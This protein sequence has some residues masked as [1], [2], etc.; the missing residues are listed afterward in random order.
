M[1]FRHL[2]IRDAAYDAI[3]KT[4]RAELHERF[5]AW[6]DAAG[7]SLGEQDEIVGYHL[8]QAYRYRLELGAD[9][10]T[11][12]AARRRRRSAP[13]GRR[14]A[15]V[16]AERLLGVDQSPRAGVRRCSLS[17]IHCELSILPDLGSAL[18]EAGDMNGARAHFDEAIERASALG[19]EQM[20]MHAVVERVVDQR[21]MHDREEARRAR[22]SR[23]LVVFEAAGD[24]RGLSRAWQLLAR[25]ALLVEG[26]SGM[27]S[28]SLEPASCT[29]ATL[30]T[31]V[32][33]S[34]STTRLAEPPL[35]RADPGRGRDPTM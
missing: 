11:R 14:R 25:G 7:G 20:R 24:E 22:Q 17:T 2:L 1:A 31:S 16:S 27:P 21:R 23:A 3:P 18:G 28:E 19:D 26:S 10:R 30:G 6:L 33:R 8:E 9:G 12:A 4:T 13:R 34:T 35:P 32:S 5:A 15:G 29:H